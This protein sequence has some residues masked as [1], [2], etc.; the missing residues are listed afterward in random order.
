MLRV[1]TDVGGTFTDYVA[2]DEGSGEL[3][4]AKAS[5]TPDIIEGIV[6]C[7]RKSHT[8]VPEVGHFVHGSTVAINTVVERKGARTGLLATEGFRNVLD[9]G[10]GNIPN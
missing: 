3:L 1:A 5:T 8:P 10:R 2:F 9:L 7:F 6:D 4:A